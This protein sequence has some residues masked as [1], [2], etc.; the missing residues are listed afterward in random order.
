MRQVGVARCFLQAFSQ[1]GFGIAVT[2]VSA[3]QISQI[4]ERRNE[5]RL[6]RERRAVLGFRSNRVAP[7]DIEQAQVHVRLGPLGIGA[8]RGDVFGEY[9]VQSR[10]HLRPHTLWL[11]N[12]KRTRG[13]DA[14]DARR[15]VDQSD[16]QALTL[17]RRRRQQCIECRCA[18]HRIRIRERS[19]DRRHRRLSFR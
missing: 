8:L 15:I 17:D 16:S 7:V 10:L 11:R 12:R 13:L 4:G 1:H 2:L 18:H 14:Y 19:L 3:K 6:Q 9:L 5:V